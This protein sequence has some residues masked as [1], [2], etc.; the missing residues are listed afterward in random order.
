VQC[1]AHLWNSIDRDG[2]YFLLSLNPLDSVAGGAPTE[3]FANEKSLALRLVDLGFCVNSIQKNM[4]GLK[5]RKETVWS[6]VSVPP[7]VF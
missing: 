7:D 2:N 6:T 3:A 1:I 5:D 4:S